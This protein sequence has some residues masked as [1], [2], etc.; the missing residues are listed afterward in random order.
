MTTPADLTDIM[1][2]LAL[3]AFCIDG[4]QFEQLRQVFTPDAQVSYNREPLEPGVEHVIAHVSGLGNMPQSQH[5]FG[6]PSIVVEGDTARARSY[7]VAYLVQVAPGTEAGHTL[8]TR[9]LSYTD[10]LVRTPDGWRISSRFHE[11]Y[12]QTVQPSPWPV[13]ARPG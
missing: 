13:G 10:E 12:W 8:M 3:Y 4:R 1:N 11:C 6:A 5:I 7:A 9:G 2:V